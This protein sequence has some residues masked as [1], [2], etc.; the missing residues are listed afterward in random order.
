MGAR[1]A[2]PLHRRRLS[3][4]R[5]PLCLSPLP[6]SWLRA[7]AGGVNMCAHLLLCAFDDWVDQLTGNALVEYAVICR[8]EM[9]ASAPHSGAPGSL[10]LAAEISYDRALI[11]LCTD[12]GI[13]ADALGFP[14]P[15]GARAPP[16][17]Y[18]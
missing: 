2:G 1:Q 17:T 4:G 11:T 18:L 6:G 16:D 3:S 5:R 15:G 9:L 10:A 8:L 13:V 12:N 14:P 7:E